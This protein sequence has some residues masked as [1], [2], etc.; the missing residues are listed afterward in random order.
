MTAVDPDVIS[1]PIGAGDGKD[2]K[3]EHSLKPSVAKRTED[4]SDMTG[5]LRNVSDS[6]LSS[7]LLEALYSI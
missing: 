3:V 2:G 5:L 7:S 6:E 1:R 4:T